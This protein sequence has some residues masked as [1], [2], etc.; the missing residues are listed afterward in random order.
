MYTT[1]TGKPVRR[2]R[3]LAVVAVLVI[4]IGITT[5]DLRPGGAAAGNTLNVTAGEYVYQTKG[6]PKP[7]WVTINFKNAGTEYHMLAMFAVNPGVTVADLKTAMSSGLKDVRTTQASQDK[8]VVSNG[9]PALRSAD[10]KFSAELHGVVQFDA[11]GY[12]QH[13]V[14]LAQTDAHAR[15]LNDGTNF[16]RARIGIGGKFY[17]DFNYNVLFDFGGYGSEDTGKIQEAWVEYAGLAHTR[18]RVGAFAPLLGL[19]D[20][21]STNSMLFLERPAM[22]EISRTLAGGDRRTGAQ[23]AFGGD[24]WLAAAAVTSNGV[25]TLN[26]NAS[27]FGSQNYDE[28]LGYTA[29]LAASPLHGEDYLVHIGANGSLVAKPGDAGPAATI[30]YGLQLR[31]RPEL[32]LDSTR[33]IDTGAIDADGARQWGLELAAQKK[34]FYVEGEYFNI[35]IDRRNP[36]LSDPNFK[37]WYVEGS[38]I[39][40]GESRRYNPLTAAFDGPSPAHPFGVDGGHGRQPEF[41]QRGEGRVLLPQPAPAEHGVLQLGTEAQIGARAEDPGRPGDDERPRAR[42]GDRL[43]R[44]PHFGGKGLVDRERARGK[45]GTQAQGARQRREARDALHRTYQ[46]LESCSATKRISALALAAS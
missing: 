4:A 9:K 36:A 43:Q 13:D 27:A 31:D 34:N 41:D 17:N 45:P 26:T 28:Q 6:T 5:L 15:D 16:R 25:S 40:T 23:A 38:W 35:H 21:V 1:H 12:F 18:L 32:S 24:H 33:L 20:A 44:G 39:L 2:S 22:A 42:L 3:A 10:G 11:G 30:R 8:V 37:G 29:R 14:P 19:E 46:R 7:G